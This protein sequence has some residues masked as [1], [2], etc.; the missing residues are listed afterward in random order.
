VKRYSKILCAVDFSEATPI[1]AGHATMLAEALGASVLV[2]YVA[3]NLDRYVNFQVSASSVN[4]F[5]KT[6]VK[7][8]EEEMKKVLDA[9]FAG[10]E[11]E[12][13][14]LS[15]YPAEL[16]VQTAKDEGCDLIV[17]GTHGRRGVG[18]VLFGSVAEKVVKKSP[19]P[20]L[21]VKPEA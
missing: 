3:P 11:A 21:T 17:M 19:L 16:I 8:A 20:V 5:V 1:V 2:L 9:H 14:V 18:R 7:G 4:D 12:G 15:G 10:V 13:G 6:V